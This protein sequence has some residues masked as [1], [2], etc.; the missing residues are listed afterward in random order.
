MVEGDADR[1]A[2]HGAEREACD[3]LPHVNALLSQQV[4]DQRRLPLGERLRRGG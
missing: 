1:E 4:A 2:D 3:R